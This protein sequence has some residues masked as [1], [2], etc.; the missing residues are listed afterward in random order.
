MGGRG[1]RL[2]G[3]VEFVIN[4]IT[5]VVN[6]DTVIPDWW[7]EGKYDAVVGTDQWE[8]DDVYWM[9]RKLGYG[10]Q[11]IQA[12][13]ATVVPLGSMLMYSADP[14]V[15]IKSLTGAAHQVDKLFRNQWG[16][17]ADIDLYLPAH[18]LPWDTVLIDSYFTTV[19]TMDDG[20]AVVL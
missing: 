17:T 5:A 16:R 11:P 3:Q 14:N 13:V 1:A 7:P 20:V 4:L 15:D 6:S 10:V 8:M 12:D 18:G 2:S 9:I 19:Y